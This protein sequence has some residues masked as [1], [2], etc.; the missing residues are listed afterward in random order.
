M[1][2]LREEW[3]RWLMLACL[4]LVLTYIVGENSWL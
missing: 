4:V 1:S 3:P 2:R